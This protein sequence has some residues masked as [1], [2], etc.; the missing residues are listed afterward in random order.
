MKFLMKLMKKRSLLI[1]VLVLLLSVTLLLSGCSKKKITLEEFVKENLT[2]QSALEDITKDDPN[3]KLEF[4]GN[5]MRILYSIS[6]EIPEESME[7]V[8]LALDTSL[9]NMEDVFTGMVKDLESST[10]IEGISIEVIYTTMDGS[11]ITK[12]SFEK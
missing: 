5:T 8:K 9:S 4:T 3:A 7:E 2:E 10:G 1:I 12:R 6:E 11:E